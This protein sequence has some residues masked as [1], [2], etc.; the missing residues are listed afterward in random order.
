MMINFEP[1]EP[2]SIIVHRDK[3]YS[4]GRGLVDKLKAGCLLRISTRGGRGGAKVWCLL[5]HAEA[6]LSPTGGRVK[7]CCLLIEIVWAD[8]QVL[9]L[10]LAQITF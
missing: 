4:M 9:N 1:A 7:S 6:S 3:A 2:L 5:V 8:G 10:C